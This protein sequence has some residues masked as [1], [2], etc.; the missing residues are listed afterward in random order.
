M[1]AYAIILYRQKT[2]IFAKIVAIGKINM[3]DGSDGEVMKLIERLRAMKV[4]V[5]QMLVELEDCVV[6]AEKVRIAG[7]RLFRVSEEIEA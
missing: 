5:S 4:E 2:S 3:V 6:I 1:G 7:D